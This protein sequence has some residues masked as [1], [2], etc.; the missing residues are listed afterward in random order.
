MIILKIHEPDDKGAFSHNQ[1]C[2]HHKLAVAEFARIRVWAGIAVHP[3]SCE[4][5]CGPGRFEI[6]TRGAIMN[7]LFAALLL[8]TSFAGDDK[9]VTRWDFENATVGKLPAGWTAAKT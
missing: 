5:G 1:W 2:S 3:N 4:F 6:F 7:S 8:V 9:L